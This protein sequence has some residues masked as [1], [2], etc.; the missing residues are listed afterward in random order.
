MNESR[1]STILLALSVLFFMLGCKHV[2]DLESSLD[3]VSEGNSLTPRHFINEGSTGILTTKSI[4]FVNLMI[5][6][7]LLSYNF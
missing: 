3:W 2:M 6:L 7:I 1:L 4:L 5:F